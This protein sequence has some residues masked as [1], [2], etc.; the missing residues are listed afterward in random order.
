MTQTVASADAIS[1]TRRSPTSVV[2]LVGL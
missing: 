1:T 2:A